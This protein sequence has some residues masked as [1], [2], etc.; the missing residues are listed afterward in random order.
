MRWILTATAVSLLVMACVFPEMLVF[1][2]RSLMT[3]HDTEIPCENIFALTTQL[4]HGGLQLWDRFDAM[5]VAYFH[6]SGGI[7]TLVNMASALIYW[8]ISP[9]FFYSAEA[10]HRIQALSFSASLPCC[11]YSADFYCCGI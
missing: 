7:Y 6:L 2:K 11:V 8:I 10:F 1:G 5:N 3:L 9:L 4:Y